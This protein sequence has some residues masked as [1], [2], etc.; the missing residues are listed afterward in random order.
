MPDELPI[1]PQQPPT[2]PSPPTEARPLRFSNKRLGLAFAV[3]AVSDV[4]GVIVTPAP[5]MMWVVDVLTA[6]LLFFALGWRWPLLMGLILEAIPGVGMLPFWLAVVGAVA[7]WGT[8]RPR[9][10]G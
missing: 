1:P 4:L 9:L 10:K 7:V 3:A 5:P 2:T 6:I 8:P